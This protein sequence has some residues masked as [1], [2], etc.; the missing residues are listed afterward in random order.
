[1][2]PVQQILAQQHSGSAEGQGFAQFAVEG[3]K[4]GQQQQ[5]LNLANRRVAMEERQQSMLLPLQQQMLGAQVANLGIQAETTKLQQ[6]LTTQQSAALPELLSLQL[7]FSQS[8]QGHM[9]PV[10][11]NAFRDV[12]LKYPYG[13]LNGV[14][15][16][17]MA[18]IEAAPKLQQGLDN[19]IKAAER[20][21]KFGVVPT[22]MDPKTGQ[23]TGFAKKAEP[24]ADFQSAQLLSQLE[25]QLE[26]TTDPTEKRVLERLVGN[27]RAKILPSGTVTEVFD[28]ATGNPI[29]RTATG[30]AA[31]N[32]AGGATNTTL[33]KA[34]QGL[35][36]AQGAIAELN[37]LEQ[38]LR[39]EDVG[40]AGVVGEQLFDIYLPQ[41][42]FN[43]ADVKRMDNRTKI[44]SLAQGLMRD[45]SDDERF[46]ENDRKFIQEMLVKP[47]MGESYPKAMSKLTTIK[48]IIAKRA[49]IQAKQTGA[50]NP[51]WAVNAIVP[52]DF[53]HAFLGGLLD[54]E[55]LLKA[56]ELG[57]IT[58]EQAIQLYRKKPRGELD[59]AT[60]P[61]A[62]R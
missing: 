38:T 26:S 48:S 18:Q 14:G 43:T 33:S 24:P 15:A 27:F 6:L 4:L 42:G 28:P 36:E 41:L 29:W 46:T 57:K 8:P 60:I 25:T 55:G 7:R 32:G 35:A 31:G 20:T 53:E 13:V 11:I 40:I 5:Q 12:A 10:L 52:S 17:I 30:K 22:Q 59:P 45:V 54:D 21:S 1:M 58:K 3:M 16:D 9:D 19:Y 2:D 23:P 37:T 34:Q 61:P 47:T 50:A 39:P 49:L 56:R 44:Q 51:T 62:A